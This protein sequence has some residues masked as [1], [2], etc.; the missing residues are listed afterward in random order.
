MN[1]VLSLCYAIVYLT[2]WRVLRV[3]DERSADGPVRRATVAGVVLWCAVAI[4]SVLQF[5]FPVL[6]E[7]GRRDGA[8]IAGGEW[9]RFVTSMLVQDGGWFGALFNLVTL[10]VTLLLVPAVFSG[11]TTVVLFLVG[12]A[13]SDLLVLVLLG[14]SGAGNSLATMFL[15]AAAAAVAWGRRRRERAVRWP[16][17]GLVAVTVLLLVLLDEH[18]IATALGLVVGGLVALVGRRRRAANRGT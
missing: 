7:L 11:A 12:G 17:L 18:G 15:V 16:A 8:A 6:L 3:A 9:W 1:V 10:A 5:L 14:E 2:S 13:V 4:P